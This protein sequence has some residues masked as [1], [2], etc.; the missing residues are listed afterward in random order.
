MTKR[1]TAATTAKTPPN[2]RASRPRAQRASNHLLDV[3][4]RRSTATRARN[5]RITRFVV[6]LTL[7]VTIGAAAYFGFVAVTDKF[8]L[9]NPE[10]DL[11]TVDADTGGL[12]STDEVLKISGIQLGTNIFKID[13]G[14]AERALRAIDQLDSVRIERHWPDNLSIIATKRHPVAWLARKNSDAFSADN[15]LLV[16]HAGLTIRPYRIESDYWQLPII[17][18]SDPDLIKSREPLAVSDLEAALDIISVNGQTPNSL[19]QIRSLDITR[20]YAVEVTNEANAHILFAPKNPIEQIDRLQKLLAHCAETGRQL[21]S[22]NLIPT[23]YTPVQFVLAA[24][25]TPPSPTSE[26]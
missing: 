21:E 6:R 23:K 10:Y 12:M 17:Y 18:C 1:R 7:L 2:R 20:G 5:R 15:A 19:L 14:A 22:V 26:H 24:N 25:A 8:F 13:I 11:R 9:S 16:D 4:V 3:K